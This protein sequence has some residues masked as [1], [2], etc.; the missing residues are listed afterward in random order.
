L[1]TQIQNGEI[2]LGIGT[3]SVNSNNKNAIQ[4]FREGCEEATYD[5]KGLAG[6]VFIIVD[7]VNNT[8]VP[9]MLSELKLNKQYT[10]SEIPEMIGAAN[11]NLQMCIHPYTGSII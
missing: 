9:V 2:K 5:G 3:G 6:K 1:N 10:G 8:L 4:D 11:D 7:G